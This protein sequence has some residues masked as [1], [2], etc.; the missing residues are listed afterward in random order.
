[1]NGWKSGYDSM[2]E[3]SSL[4]VEMSSVQCESISRPFYVTVERIV[5]FIVLIDSRSVRLF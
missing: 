4:N 1:M 5:D 3:V 2:G